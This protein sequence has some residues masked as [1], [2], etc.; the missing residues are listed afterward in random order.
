MQGHGFSEEHPESLSESAER[1]L[2]VEVGLSRGRKWPLRT[3]DKEKLSRETLHSCFL[4]LCIFWVS[5]GES[6]WVFF[7]L[8]LFS[9]LCS[10]KSKMCLFK[11]VHE[12]AVLKKKQIRRNTEPKTSIKKFFFCTSAR[13]NVFMNSLLFQT[14]NANCLK[15]K[16]L[17]CKITTYTAV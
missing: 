8:I 4:Y 10:H 1:K 16:C 5:E 2:P 6:C 12:S 14:F 11:R 3:T 7:F 15:M 17:I 13:Q 9:P